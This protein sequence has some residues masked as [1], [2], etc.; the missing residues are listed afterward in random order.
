MVSALPTVAS[1]PLAWTAQSLATQLWQLSPTD[2]VALDIDTLRCWGDDQ[3]D[4]IAAWQPKTLGLPAIHA[5]AE[6]IRDRLDRGPGFCLVRGMAAGQARWLQ[7][8][9]YLAVGSALGE[10]LENYGRL[11]DV[12]DRDVCYRTQAVPVSMTRESTGFHTDSSARAVKPDYIALLCLQPGQFGGENRLCSAVTVRNYLV[13]T[14]PDA[15]ELLHQPLI[16]DVVTPGADRDL[17]RIRANAFPIFEPAGPFMFR[18]MRYWIETGHRRAEMP[19]SPHQIAALDALD[20][21]LEQPSHIHRLRMAKG[22]QLWV[23]NRCLAHD[24]TAYIDDPG[25][26]RTMVRLWVQRALT[27]R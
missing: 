7:R 9:T 13:R 5:L 25:N 11:Y 1:S 18:Y 8:L 15:L 21:A 19:L 24:R 3:A 22:D 12:K 27:S 26:P 16:R 20:E 23:N 17:S 6:A 14:A 10:V 2:A 4:P